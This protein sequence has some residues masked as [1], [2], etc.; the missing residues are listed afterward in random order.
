MATTLSNTDKPI[1]KDHTPARSTIGLKMMM[2]VSGLIFVGYVIAHMYGNLMIFGGHEV[3]N[4]YAHHLRT[5]FVPVLPYEGLLWILRVVLLVALVAH[6]YSGVKLWG[7]A[8]GARTQRY[9][10][11]KAAAASLS[12]RTMRW[13]GIALLVFVVF[14]LAQFTFLWVN[15]G[16]MYGTP[17]ERV[18][19]AFQQWWLT[20]IYALALAALAMHLNHGVW[21]ACQTLGLTNTATSRRLAK[22]AGRVLSSVVVIGFLLPPLAILFGAIK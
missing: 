4:E 18:V 6:V 13:G 5:M 16:G 8:Q 20:L 15:V 22:L 14:H 1:K 11:K 19:V 9:A 17:A 12:S 10:V 7:R 21:S 2:A 3:F